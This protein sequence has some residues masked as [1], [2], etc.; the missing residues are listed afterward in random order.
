MY[1]PR[2]IHWREYLSEG[3][4]TLQMNALPLKLLKFALSSQQS[5]QF[6]YFC[7]E[8]SEKRHI[9]YLSSPQNLL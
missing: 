6:Y 9:V 5:A 8:I 7:C 2:G 1:K 4:G 3:E